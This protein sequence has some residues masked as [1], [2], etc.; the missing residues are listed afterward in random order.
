MTKKE[1]IFFIGQLTI[2]K[3]MN[4]LLV[5]TT[6]D[7]PGIQYCHDTIPGTVN[8]YYLPRYSS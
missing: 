5:F 8:W 2:T 1:G 3:G 4:V 6:P 7:Y